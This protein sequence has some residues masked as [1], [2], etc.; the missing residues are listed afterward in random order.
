MGKNDQPI[1]NK[2]NP[3]KN[4]LVSR[5]KEIFKASQEIFVDSVEFKANGL[6]AA[7]EKGWLGHFLAGAGLA[8][9]ILSYYGSTN[10]N[11]FVEYGGYGV[12]LMDMIYVSLIYGP[13]LLKRIKTKQKTL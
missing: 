7:Y 9:L 1:T 8:G 4:D 12:I 13:D 2:E 5:I 10:N 11:E 3:D 6:K